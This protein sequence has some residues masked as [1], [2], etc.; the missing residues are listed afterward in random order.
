MSLSSIV[1]SL[2][3]VLSLKNVSLFI[4]VLGVVLIWFDYQSKSEQLTTIKVLKQVNDE[5][6][7]I[8][9]GDAH[10]VSEIFNQPS[11]AIDAA[12]DRVLEQSKTAC[13]QP[14]LPSAASNPASTVRVTRP[15]DVGPQGE[16][17]DYEIERLV[18]A[19]LLSCTPIIC[20]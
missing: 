8:A 12:V 7:A 4:V 2:S 3:G 13:C 14:Q 6:A 17:R 15:V 19:G 16:L 10:A 9:K 20:Q 11:P 5:S 1:E 18:D